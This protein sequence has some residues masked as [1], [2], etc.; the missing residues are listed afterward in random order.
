LRLL[1]DPLSMAGGIFNKP[2]REIFDSID[3][4]IGSGLAAFWRMLG[5]LKVG[6]VK[7]RRFS[8]G[9]P[10]RLA[11]SVRIGGDAKLET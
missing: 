10:G 1:L 5:K 4:E 3:R 9:L 6:L 2:L 8:P 7:Y 11:Y